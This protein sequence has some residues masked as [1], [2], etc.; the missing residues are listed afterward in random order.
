M[1]YYA[2][3]RI[4]IKSPLRYFD[5]PFEYLDPGHIHAYINGIEVGFQ[6]HEPQTIMLDRKAIEN[7][8]VLIKRETPIDVPIVD[9]QAGA[10]LLEEQLDLQNRQ[11][12]FVFQ[13]F[14]DRFTDAM[15]VHKDGYFD[16]QNR[17]IKNIKDGSEDKDAL[18]V[19]Q[20]K[21]FWDKFKDIE[22]N[23][24]KHSADTKQNLQNVLNEFMAFLPKKRNDL[25]G[26]LKDTK[27]TLS[28]IKKLHKEG[29]NKL[30]DC[31][32]YAESL[33]KFANRI[34]EYKRNNHEDIKTA[35]GIF[36]SRHLSKSLKRTLTEHT[37]KFMRENGLETLVKKA[38]R[39]ADSRHNSLIRYMDNVA[40]TVVKKEVK[41]HIETTAQPFLDKTITSIISAKGM[42]KKIE[43]L[44]SGVALKKKALDILQK[45]MTKKSD[46]I[47]Q[48]TNFLLEQKIDKMISEQ[49]ERMKQAP[50]ETN[51]FFKAQHLMRVIE[52]DKFKPEEVERHKKHLKAVLKTLEK[53]GWYHEL[54]KK[55]NENKK[56][57]QK[58][59]N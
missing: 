35:I 11:P 33:G 38:K 2:Q 1:R 46:N 26:I 3:K 47:I 15:N 57:Q 12:L 39:Y 27:D 48:H 51:D 55:T 58:K 19:G 24:H 53:L 36:I 29:S 17:T 41:N 23:L 18:N 30:K 34:D 9:F 49:Y 6:F 42:N 4:P 16:A 43:A 56:K 13:E 8:V 10:T 20:V 44:T 31:K 14:L 25:S 5:V 7:D 37:N 21:S 50:K 22:K 54:L 28:T 40:E 45:L 32:D 52:G 59:E